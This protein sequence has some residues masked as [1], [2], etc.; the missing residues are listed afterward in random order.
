MQI[1]VDADACPVKQEVY[2]VARRYRLE[3]TL[4]AASPTGKPGMQAVLGA[5]RQRRDIDALLRAPVVT[6]QATVL[7]LRIDD[8]RI[9]RVELRLVT[10]TAQ[11]QVPIG[12]CD[13]VYVGRPRR[14]AQGIVVLRAATNVVE[15]LDEIG[16]DPVKLRNR[17]VANMPPR[18]A[19][20]RRSAPGRPAGSPTACR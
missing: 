19:P 6:C 13:A 3:V 10:V 15:R 1:W 7:I 4:V 20:I 9:R 14:R 2:R 11:H 17:Q 12:V 18:R 5:L 8:I 16:L